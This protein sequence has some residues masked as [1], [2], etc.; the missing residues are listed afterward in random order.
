MRFRATVF[1]TRFFETDSTYYPKGVT[2]EEMLVLER[3]ILQDDHELMMN[4]PDTIWELD[5]QQV[6]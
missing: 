1:A 3:E 4:H 2:T 5:V 6:E